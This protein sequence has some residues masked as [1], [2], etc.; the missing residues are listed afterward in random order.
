MLAAAAA[1]GAAAAAAAAGAA[2]AG[3]SAAGAAAADASAAGAAAAGASAA[4]A[5]A[6]AAAY[7]SSSVAAAAA[8]S[9]PVGAMASAVDAASGGRLWTQLLLPPARGA[10]LVWSHLAAPGRSARGAGQRLHCWSAAR[11]DGAAAAAAAA[12]EGWRLGSRGRA[13][14]LAAGLI[15]CWQERRS[16]ALGAAGRQGRAQGWVSEGRGKQRQGAPSC[17]A[18]HSLGVRGAPR[19]A[20]P[21]IWRRCRAAGGAMPRGGRGLAGR[22]GGRGGR[23]RVLCAQQWLERRAQRAAKALF[24]R[25]AAA[26]GGWGRLGRLG[27]RAAAG[28]G[29][30]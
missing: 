5:G 22:T 21:I 13:R 1:A 7:R 10:A 20:P 23:R 26:E 8:A 28:S 12:A 16:R 30:C 19:R 17:G 29:D 24:R 9:V 11:A 25:E 15:T 27:R 14:S 6:S 2:A 4:A 18:A 3:T